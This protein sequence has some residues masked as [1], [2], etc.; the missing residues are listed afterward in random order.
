MRKTIVSHNIYTFSMFQHINFSNV[1][2][3]VCRLLIDLFIQSM[4]VPFAD[5]SDDF[6]NH[7]ARQCSL[8]NTFIF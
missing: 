5:F 1:L 8:L 3:E 2:L 6:G 7:F 4:D